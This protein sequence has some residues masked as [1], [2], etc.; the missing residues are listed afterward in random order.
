MTKIKQIQLLTKKEINSLEVKN[1]STTTLIVRSKKGG[2]AKTTS[3]TSLVHGLARLGEKLNIVYVTADVN[4]GAKRLFTEE[5]CKTQFPKGVYFKSIA[6]KDAWK[7]STSKINR[8]IAAEL[9]ADERLIEHAKAKGLEITEEDLENTFYLERDG[10]I[11]KVDYLIYD[12]AGGVDQ[13]ETDQIARDSLNGFITVELAN[14]LDSKNNALDSIRDMALEEIAYTKRFLTEQGYDVEKIPADKFNALKE[15]I[16][17]TYTYI[18]SK[19]YQGAMSVSDPR[20]TVAELKKLEEEFGI[21]IDF[22][23][24]P[25]VKFN[26]L[27]KRGLSYLITREEAKAQGHSIGRVKTIEKHPEFQEFMTDFI[28][29][30]LGGYTAN[31]Y[32]LMTKGR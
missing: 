24:L 15:Q 17:F 10:E 19:N 23:I 6:I 21:K 22:L 2:C 4:E 1:D 12:I 9:L 26:E 31:K 8:E 5:Y 32:E 3:A 25:C 16:G 11:Q 29:S 20:E 18:Y 14:D 30:V 13:I 27:K 28:K 7:K